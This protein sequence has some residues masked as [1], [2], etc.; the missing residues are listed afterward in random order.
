MLSK[1]LLL[2]MTDIGTNLNVFFSEVLIQW[3]RVKNIKYLESGAHKLL[4]GVYLISDV[5]GSNPL[6]DADYVVFGHNMFFMLVKTSGW[7]KHGLV[8][9]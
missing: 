9:E 1:L 3:W 7:H 2:Q 5:C 4:D 8:V 6:A